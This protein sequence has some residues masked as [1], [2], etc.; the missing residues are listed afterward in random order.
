VLILGLDWIIKSKRSLIVENDKI[1]LKSSDAYKSEKKVR[2]AG[3]EE[4]F[5]L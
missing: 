3:I 1:V 2:F 4:K 5:C